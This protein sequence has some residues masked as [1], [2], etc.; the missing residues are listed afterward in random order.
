MPVT[1]N[2]VSLVS[3]MSMNARLPF[4]LSNS[5]VALHARTR[6]R[7]ALQPSWNRCFSQ[8]GRR[9]TWL[10]LLSRPRRH[11]LRPPKRLTRPRSA[12][13]ATLATT[14]NAVLQGRLS[15]S[16][17]MRAI[18]ATIAVAFTTLASG[19]L[20]RMTVGCAPPAGA[21][22]LALRFGIALPGAICRP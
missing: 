15:F 22:A 19:L 11:V 2:L 14:T 5:S 20:A 10:H 12:L 13:Y 16:Y 21:L 6:F 8:R 1:S 7:L 17:A 18:T 4:S 3:G 9:K